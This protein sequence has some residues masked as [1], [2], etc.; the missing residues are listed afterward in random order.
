MKLAARSTER[1]R[2]PRSRT[3]T[4]SSTTT[5]ISAATGR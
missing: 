2:W 1:E 3:S 4:A 5:C